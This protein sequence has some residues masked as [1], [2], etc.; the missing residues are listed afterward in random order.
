[1]R[2]SGTCGIRA[3]IHLLGE[4]ISQSAGTSSRGLSVIV[5]GRT[6]CFS[7][8]GGF[9]FS[10]GSHRWYNITGLPV[11]DANSW[12]EGTFDSALIKGLSR[13]SS[14]CVEIVNI[15]KDLEI[16]GASSPGIVGASSSRV[17]GASS[18]IARASSP[19]VAGQL[20]P[21][22]A[23]NH[24]TGSPEHQQVMTWVIAA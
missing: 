5:R 21:G 14:L 13:A 19:G 9:Y 17:A 8:G 20:S 15:D 6:C 22:I 3:P 4:D 7:Q 11:G 18:G 24:R 16:V 23:G 10:A 2:E 12:L 1:M